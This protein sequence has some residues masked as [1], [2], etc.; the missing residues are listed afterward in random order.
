MNIVFCRY[1]NICEPDY[2]EAFKVLGI[3]IVEVLINDIEA[4]SISQKAQK[5]GELVRKA[6]PMFVFSINYFPYI[7][8]VCQ[9]LNIKYV[10]ISVT[11]PMVEIYNTTIRNRCNR[12]FLF[13]RQQYLSVCDENPD[14]I[15]YLPLGAAV[16]RIGDALGDAGG[17][18]RFDISFVGSLYNEKDPLG[19]RLEGRFE[20]LINDQIGMTVSGQDYL[21]NQIRSEDVAKIKEMA[22]DFYPSDMCIRNIDEFV[23][24]N[25][26]L[27]PHMAYIERVRL[28]NMLAGQDE[29]NV[30]LFTN[31]DTSDLVG[32]KVHGPVETLVQ[33][34]QVFHHSRI[35][36]NISVRSIKTGIPQR[37]WDVLASKGFLL[38]NYQQE[39]PEFFE[40]GKHLVAYESPDELKKLVEYY[41]KH[42]EER[43]AIADTGYELVKQKGSVLGRVVEMIKRIG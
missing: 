6:T 3:D 31:S 16:N 21:E 35:N 14:G 12:V 18:Y 40:I 10:S 27:S 23:A 30:H 25:N 2:V 22:Q 26:Y 42:E 9:T 19:T 8:I 20:K 29:Y 13:D 33:M 15:F 17:G 32:V 5:L 28:L 36:L 11:C 4:S 37:V 7:S 41:L 38:T 39:L 1:Q 34:P 24:I 43:K